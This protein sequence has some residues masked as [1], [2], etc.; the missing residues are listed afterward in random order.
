MHLIIQLNE[1]NRFFCFLNDGFNDD[2]IFRIE[3]VIK[4][5]SSNKD[6]FEFKDDTNNTSISVK[7]E[8]QLVFMYSHY[9]DGTIKNKIILLYE[10]AGFLHEWRLNMSPNFYSPSDFTLKIERIFVFLGKPYYRIVASLA[11]EKFVL[12]PKYG[13][14]KCDTSSF[15]YDLI[16]SVFIAKEMGVTQP[17]T[18]ASASGNISGNPQELIEFCHKENLKDNLVVGGS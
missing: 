9:K 10:V 4:E 17:L 15:S 2:V 3:N 8:K 16:E 11:D 5:L 6:V 1:A 13:F 14:L 18:I 7:N 12:F